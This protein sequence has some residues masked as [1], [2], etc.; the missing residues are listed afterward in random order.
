M[1]G[2]WRWTEENERRLLSISS[3]SGLSASHP[4]APKRNRN[5]PSDLLSNS[6]DR[7][8]EQVLGG[9]ALSSQPDIL[10]S[11][12]FLPPEFP[13]SISAWYFAFS[14]GNLI[15]RTLSLKCGWQLPQLSPESQRWRGSDRNCQQRSRILISDFFYQLRD[16]NCLSPPCLTLNQV[17]VS[18]WVF[19]SLEIANTGGFCQWGD[20]LTTEVD[21]LVNLS[22]VSGCRWHFGAWRSTWRKTG[23]RCYCTQ[24]VRLYQVHGKFDCTRYMYRECD[25]TRYI[26]GAI[27]PGTWKIWLYQVHV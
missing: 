5:S 26:E 16:L 2:T 4:S 6:V 15:W 19:C 8:T 3:I 22:K 11:H 12:L 9:I 17:G 21:Q 25:C 18:D 7:K 23:T 10:L 13:G 20:H 27:V 24:R 1:F 14:C